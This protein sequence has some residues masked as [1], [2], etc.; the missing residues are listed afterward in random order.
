MTATATATFQLDEPDV[1]ACFLA[2]LAKTGT[3]VASCA[4][5]GIAIGHAYYARQRDAAFAAD[6][7][8]ARQR[9]TKKYLKNDPVRTAKFLVALAASGC[10]ASAARTAGIAVETIYHAKKTDAAFAADWAEARSQALDLAEGVLIKGAIFG[11]RRTETIGDVT[12]V[13]V[14]M[15][16]KITLALLDR[17]RPTDA[18]LRS[19]TPERVAA[20][21]ARMIEILVSGNGLRSM[22]DHAPVLIG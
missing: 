6:W 3:V 18:P 12:K 17:A 15:Q 4:A 13:I 1:R 2:A 20:A 10:A 22:D 19:A 7:D 14:D 5:A 21:R 16:P 11:H 8:A 9:K